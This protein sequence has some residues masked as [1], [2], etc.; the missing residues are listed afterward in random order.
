M[1]TP[2]PES[3]PGDNPPLLAKSV[4][5]TL[6]STSFFE[7]V[8]D[9]MVAV[10]PEGVIVQAN[11]QTE[12]LFGYSQGEL[13]GQ[14]V[15]MLVPAAHREHHH[16][17][18]ERFRQQ[19]STR[20]MGAALDLRG[21]RKDGSE[22]PVEISL[23][24][25]NTEQGMLVLSAIR[26]ISD[27]KRIEEELRRAHEE[28][29]ASKDRQ[30]LEY[31]NRLALIVDSSQDAI[32]GKDL[33]GTIT[34]WNKGAENIYGY[35]AE[36]V[37]SKSI[38]M[39]APKSRSDEIPEILEKV[40]RGERVEYFET[41]RVRKDGQHLNVSISISPIRDAKGEIVGASAIARDVTSQK[42]SEGLL[43]QAQKMEAVGRLAGGVAHDFN[44]ILGIISACC[45]LLRSRVDLNGVSQ[46]IDNIQEAS[47]RGA[48][49]TRQLL[50]FSRRQVSLQPRLIDVN[51]SFK[52]FVK[53]L[54]PLMG[55]DV[56]VIVRP[57]PDSA[58][59]ECDPAQL[60]QILLNIA[61]N[62]RD[63][64]PKGG[65]LILETSMQ[66]FDA[67]LAGQHP[68]MKEG[69]YVLLAI[70]DTGSGMDSVTLS[71]I[72]DPF[73]TTKE[74][75][76]GTGLGLATVYGIVKQSGGH[77]WVYSEVG[78]GTT[79]K[80]YLPAADY[81]L[82]LAP[83]SE[84]EMLPPKAHDKTVLLVEDD[85]LM[86]T[87]T[88][89]MLQDHG[90]SVVEAEDGNSALEQLGAHSRPIHAALT[91]VV[92]RG[93]S[94]PEL[95]QKLKSAYPSIKVVFMSGYTGELIA[96]AGECDQAITL[97]LLEKPFT[98]AALL[99]TLHAACR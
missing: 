17:H 51:D 6:L 97:T 46:Y 30:L 56:Q 22:F 59:V 57:G 84:V 82:G 23:S 10:N 9:A 62:A 48:S 60:D 53:L 39:L 70:S 36:E 85:A 79:F 28:L 99:K 96:Q 54:R 3:N 24:P 75:G 77:I 13:I 31:Q 38:S 78:R 68:P 42:R 66:D 34:H 12:L 27:R 1:S 88:R 91:D 18:R 80:I 26:D 69:R 98:R 35:T 5:K 71:R 11:S 4:S 67:T 29:A 40:R 52:E 33:N 25:V 73:F 93:M 14:K 47:R 94:G 43:R 15:E 2:L 86:R 20:R 19:P 32:I 37:V 95:A 41:E 92:M 72:F 8:P 81:K 76:K 89:Q 58:I 45:E 65:K 44:N 87:L 64:M 21:R 83:K 61:V 74:V 7:A 90:Y 50:A 16:H 63:A 49:L 55:D